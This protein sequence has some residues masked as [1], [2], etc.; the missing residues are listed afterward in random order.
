MQT[1]FDLLVSVFYA[2][3][4]LL[5]MRV[6][7][8]FF[9]RII[10]SAF[11]VWFFIY[12]DVGMFVL[13]LAD[14]YV[15]VT[16]PGVYRSFGIVLI[17]RFGMSGV[18]I[19]AIFQSIIHLVSVSLDGSSA[20][21]EVDLRRIAMKN[22]IVGFVKADALAKLVG[23]SLLPITA[24]TYCCCQIVSV[25]RQGLLGDIKTSSDME[26]FLTQTIRSL[27]WRAIIQVMAILLQAIPAAIG[28]FMESFASVANT[29]VGYQLGLFSLAVASSLAPLITLITRPDCRYRLVKI[30]HLPNRWRSSEKP[31]SHPFYSNKNRNNS[32]DTHQ[33][34]QP[35][36]GRFIAQS[37]VDTCK[38]FDTDS[39]QTRSSTVD[40][41]TMTRRR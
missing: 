8:E 34:L 27:F 5:F 16:Y 6:S 33:S 21:T 12:A 23:C 19:H 28:H 13:L 31:E 17:L 2:L 1:F 38:S 4:T 25:P 30:F 40:R 7:G 3:Y 37:P 9:C 26:C 22:E 39:R 36:P 10:N 14:R 24:I 15:A 35:P 29:G 20:C 11:P 32:R 41:Q 18:F